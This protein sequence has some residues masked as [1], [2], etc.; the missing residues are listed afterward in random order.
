M[1]VTD[2]HYLFI[3]VLCY[4]RIILSVEAKYRKNR[5]FI[6]VAMSETDTFISRIKRRVVTR[7]K[8]LRKQTDAR[9]KTNGAYSTRYTN[10]FVRLSRVLLLRRLKKCIE[11]YPGAP[12][13]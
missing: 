13:N 12:R 8:L 5:V 1:R 2:G 7:D 6:C 11:F 9:A 3:F 4:R 10:R